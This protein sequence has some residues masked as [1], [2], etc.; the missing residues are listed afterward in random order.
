MRTTTFCALLLSLAACGDDDAVA[1]PD[2]AVADDAALPADDAATDPDGGE[3]DPDGGG[4]PT[5]GGTATADVIRG[6]FESTGGVRCGTIANW[7]A[8]DGPLLRGSMNICGDDLDAL[9]DTYVDNLDAIAARGDHTVMALGQ[10]LNL[11][12][13]WLEACETI[14][15]NDGRFMGETCAPWDPT[16]QGLLRDFLIDE[17]GP[18]VAGHE[19]LLGV[20]FTISSMTNGYEMHF[21][22]TR[23]DL[24]DYPGDETFRAAYLAIMDIYQEAFDV[25]IVFEAGH[26]PFGA[27]PDCETPLALY[28][29]A[30][31]TY[32]PS[33]VGVAMW[34]CSERF[35]VNESAP[36]WETRPLLE[37]AAA[38]GVSMGCQ[39]VGSF[40]NGACRFSSDDIADYGSN[41][42]RDQDACAP[43]P[44]FDP[45]A[46]CVDTM[47]WFV[48]TARRNDESM[49]IQGTWAENW[50]ADYA[51]G[52]IYETSETC[53]AAMDAVAY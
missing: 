3:T 15:V 39:T 9:R 46:A 51:P 14:P 37:E 31:D 30:R 19:A 18:A 27:D 5:D 40:T 43:S 6:R 34:N 42:G 2:A 35:F 7:N 1:T 12:P 22:V 20:Y 44:T 24:P 25:P 10:G 48:G 47:G 23:D 49:L 52:G 21:R 13:S 53:R 16:Y 36:E 4:D 11:P 8:P 50:S 29:H 32:G 26:C 33:Q 41:I 45:E 38:D 28:R 17:V